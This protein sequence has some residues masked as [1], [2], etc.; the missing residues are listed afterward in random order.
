MMWHWDELFLIILQFKILR[1]RPPVSNHLMIL[2]KISDQ[3]SKILRA[4]TSRGFN[5]SL[6]CRKKTVVVIPRTRVATV[7]FRIFAGGWFRWSI[8]GRKP[9]VD[10]HG[11]KSR[12][13][14]N[15][16]DSLWYKRHYLSSYSN[17]RCPC[18]CYQSFSKFPRH[19]NLLLLLPVVINQIF[20]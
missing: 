9:E 11:Y 19:L 10:R 5:A 17:C 13:S 16:C 14:F 20:H 8:G 1:A 3:R 4:T 2:R 7:S 18:H 6:R 12:P 15:T